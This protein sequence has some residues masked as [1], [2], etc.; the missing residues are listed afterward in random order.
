MAKKTKKIQIKGHANHVDALTAQRD[1]FKEACGATRSKDGYN[2]PNTTNGTLLRQMPC[3]RTSSQRFRMQRN[4]F[5]ENWS[6]RSVRSN[7]CVEIVNGSNT[8]NGT[9]RQRTCT[10]NSN[11][12]WSQNLF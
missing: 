8:Q 10:G 3:R 4:F 9:V 1:T 7:R 12:K 2:V 5:W 11:Q 6:I